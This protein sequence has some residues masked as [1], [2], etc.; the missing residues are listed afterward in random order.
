[1][2]PARPWRIVDALNDPNAAADLAVY[3]SQF[4]LPACTVANGC[5]KQLNQNGATSPL[6]AGDTGWAGEESLDIDMVS[7]IC[8][9]CHIDLIEANSADNADLYTAEN[10]AA[11]PANFISNSWG[12]DE[13]RRQTADDATSTTRARPSRSAPATTLPAHHY[14]ATSQYVTAVGG[15]CLSTSS[16]SRGWTETAWNDA[17]SG[18]S[19][20]D[21]KPS[22]QTVTTAARSGPKRTFRGRRPEHRRRGLPDLRRAGWLVYGGTSVAS[23]IIASV[24]AL[25]GTPAQDNGSY[26]YSHTGNLLRRDE[27]QQRHLRHRDSAPPAPAGTAR[28]ASARR[29]A[30]PRSA[31][32][33]VA[34][35][36][37]VTVT[38]PRVTR[39]PRS[40]TR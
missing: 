32:R 18:C 21:A 39:Q 17:G 25:A 11:S 9:H 10:T 3:R 24:Y 14:P 2:A 1:M 35:A 5:F 7:A 12:G 30:P 33:A 4:G 38:Q 34:A 40:A 27:R 8:P 37:T 23:P 13:D 19:A 15:T 16:N 6:P 29:T 26:L 28:P 20:Y 22:W 31:A 36:R